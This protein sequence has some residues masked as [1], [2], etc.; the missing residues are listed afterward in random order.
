MPGYSMQNI[1]CITHSAMSQM[2]NRTILRIA[3]QKRL[4]GWTGDLHSLSVSNNQMEQIE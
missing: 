4:R 2:E 1:V 3:G